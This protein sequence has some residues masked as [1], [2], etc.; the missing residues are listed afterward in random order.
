EARLAP[1]GEPLIARGL[2][3]LPPALLRCLNRFGIAIVLRGQRRGQD[4][5]K[6]ATSWERNSL[7]EHAPPGPFGSLPS[8]RRHGTGRRSSWAR[9]GKRCCTDGAIRW[10]YSRTIAPGLPP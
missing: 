8:D 9:A 6:R 3:R 5:R 1:P 2:R 10:R 7:S 4:Q